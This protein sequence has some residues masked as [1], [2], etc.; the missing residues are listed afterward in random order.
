MWIVGFLMISCFKNSL[1]VSMIQKLSAFTI[2][3]PGLS[4][5]RE[6]RI[7]SPKAQLSRLLYQPDCG[8]ISIWNHRDDSHT[9]YL[10]CRGGHTPAFDTDQWRATS[11]GKRVLEL[12]RRRTMTV[13]IVFRVIKA[14]GVIV[15][16]CGNKD[17][18]PFSKTF[19][20][21]SGESSRRYTQYRLR[22][23]SRVPAFPS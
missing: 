7:L 19:L 15:E 18:S 13:P 21:F 20:P 4:G 3:H 12:S 11:V 8:S 2:F 9:S 14:D 6:I 5:K 1:G 16:K 10:F 22:A 23:E 17:L